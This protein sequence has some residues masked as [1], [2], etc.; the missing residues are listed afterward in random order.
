MSSH[1]SLA[2]TQVAILGLGLMGGSLALAL[3]GHCR[4]L[5]AYDPD[6][7]TLALASARQIVDIASPDLPAILPQ[8]DL[9]VLAA[10]VRATLSLIR[11]LPSLHPGSAVVLDLASTK[12]EVCRAFEKL[13]SRFDPIGGHPM[14]G[15]ET[16]GFTNAEAS[17]Y[18]GAAFALTPLERTSPQARTL[19]VQVVEAIGARPVWLD[20]AT[21]DRWAA[22]TSHMP[23]LLAVALTLATQPDVK[24]LVGPGFRS[25]SRLASSS[26]RMMADILH[27]NRENV[28]AALA[29]F[30]G[31]LEQ[32]QAA[33]QQEDEAIL[34]D[35]IQRGIAARD[36]LTG[37]GSP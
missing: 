35:K 29:L 32:I 28:L 17:L 21:H 8:A 10:P 27:T 30:R 13:P 9:I 20:A 34:F 22:A 33:L 31:E 18:Q 16:A 12:T 7:A 5:L 23:Y 25:T 11:Q 15:K 19:A 4:R 2:E 26:A 37:G 24:P 36:Y 1:L 6:P 14:C 3:K